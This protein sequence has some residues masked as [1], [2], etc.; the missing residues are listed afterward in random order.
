MPIITP[1]TMLEVTLDIVELII[2]SYI[3]FSLGMLFHIFLT[4]SK[5]DNPE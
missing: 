2:L 4:R 5:N 1:V 3:V